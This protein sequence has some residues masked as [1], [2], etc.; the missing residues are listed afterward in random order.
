MF[1]KV[2]SHRIMQ[3]SRRNKFKI[4]MNSFAG[5]FA[6]NNGGKYHT[7][8]PAE[9]KNFF[10]L[11]KRFFT[12]DQLTSSHKI[13]ESTQSNNISKNLDEESDKHPK[14]EF[15]TSKIFKRQWEKAF[16]TCPR[17]K[18]ISLLNNQEEVISLGSYIGTKD[19][20]YRYSYNHQIAELNP[21]P[22]IFNREEA[23]KKTDEIIMNSRKVKRRILAAVMSTSGGGKTTFL[24]AYPLSFMSGREEERIPIYITFNEDTG[25]KPNSEDVIELSLN[26]RILFNFFHHI[27]EISSNDKSI[28]DNPKEKFSQFLKRNKTVLKAI[29]PSEL[30]D[31]IN[32]LTGKKIILLVDEIMKAKKSKD[33]TFRTTLVSL[34]GEILDENNDILDL[35]ISTLDAAVTNADVTDGSQRSIMYANLTPMT[36]IIKYFDQDM[37]GQKVFKKLFNLQLA[38][39][40]ASP[41]PRATVKMINEIFTM[42][43]EERKKINNDLLQVRKFQMKHLN[44]LL[45]QIQNSRNYKDMMVKEALEVVFAQETIKLNESTTDQ[46]NDTKK[47]DYLFTLGLF[48]NFTESGKPVLNLRLIEALL[49]AMNLKDWEWTPAYDFY[50]LA[51]DEF[52][53]FGVKGK[54]EE[55]AML[56]NMFEVFQQR[57]D[58][59]LRKYHF[60]GGFLFPKSEKASQKLLFKYSQIFPKAICY[61]ESD[62]EF[63]LRSQY[64]INNKFFDKDARSGTMKTVLDFLMNTQN[65]DDFINN[66]YIFR[67]IR[68]GEAFDWAAFDEGKDQSYIT[69]YQDNYKLEPKDEEADIEKIK[70]SLKACKEQFEIFKTALSKFDEEKGRKLNYRLIFRTLRTAPANIEQFKTDNLIFLG[71]EE[72]SDRIEGIFD[73]RYEFF[74]R[75]FFGPVQSNQ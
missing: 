45:D 35:V 18:D 47:Y 17:I 67:N 1:K 59:I 62:K 53:L 72:I 41:N 25:F 32:K 33:L 26:S 13:K 38:V 57:L 73:L 51:K 14:K 52:N 43:D 16:K 40:T 29:D 2:T 4:H 20:E 12:K 10:V 28:M 58:V 48:M 36:D 3:L 63:F 39:Y 70:K 65:Y 30:I 55:Q 54:N 64:Y 46:N 34:L 19:Y 15:I 61:G 8:L 75:R 56:T 49:S 7:E 37:N 44:F 60:Y 66:G 27:Y 42:S 31:F 68:N 9:R 69:F 5:F 71:K 21:L 6:L 74:K 24:R 11:T 50:E 23:Y 22:N